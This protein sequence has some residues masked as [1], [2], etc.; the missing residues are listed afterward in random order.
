M[1]I[2]NEIIAHHFLAR[3]AHFAIVYI[4]TLYKS[5]C[6]TMQRQLLALRYK[7]FVCMIKQQKVR[8]LCTKVKDDSRL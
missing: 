4:M 1:C 5:I 3:D 8:K 2:K 7:L 6:H